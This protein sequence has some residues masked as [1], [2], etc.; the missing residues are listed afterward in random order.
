MPENTR[1]EIGNGGTE[2]FDQLFGIMADQMRQ[3]DELEGFIDNHA[4][5]AQLAHNALE[6]LD[7]TLPV[8]EH[9]PEDMLSAMQLVMANH[10]MTISQ[11]KQSRLVY[12][13]QPTVSDLIGR[14][15]LVTALQ[16]DMQAIGT[17]R[18]NTYDEFDG[19]SKWH[20]ERTGRIRALD[21]SP[22]Q[23]GAVCL[24]GRFGKLHIVAP[25][26]DRDA[27]YQPKFSVELL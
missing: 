15:V 12:I 19:L 4:R 14:K 26:V 6:G 24:G 13:G 21:C 27:D 23:G 16:P 1:I 22:V 8:E 18:R 10:H 7:F 9:E 11:R 25:L 2:P 20:K 3:Y 5:V 17:V